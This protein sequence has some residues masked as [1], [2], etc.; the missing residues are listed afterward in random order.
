VTAKV[1]SISIAPVKGLALV[2]PEKVSLE[3][4]GVAENRRFY[5]VDEE[6]RRYGLLRDGR[7][8]QVEAE[9]D[10]D[11]THL[12]LRFPDGS[13]VAGEVE[14]GAP[15]TTDFYGRPVGGRF[16]EGPWAEALSAHAGRPVRVVR[17]DSPGA[18]VDRVLGP[19]SLASDASAEE[20]SAHA[21]VPVDPRRFRMLFG[22]AGVPPHGED[23]WVG[24]ELRIGDAAVR[25]L[26][27]VARCAITT[28]D[29]ATGERDLDTLRLIDGYRP[30][31][32]AGGIC[33]GVWGDVVRPG[34]VRLGDPVEPR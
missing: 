3:S 6:G 13:V 26:G 17:A 7:L 8:V 2:H 22:I 25:V 32:A 24:R 20:L 16:V 28:Q 23:E 9:T 11:G 5:L 12:S 15:V 19:V 30:R 18:G 10:A 27:R 4:F 33:F 34:R 21:G 29:P 1:S 14:P 31:D